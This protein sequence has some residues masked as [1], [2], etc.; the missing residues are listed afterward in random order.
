MYVSLYIIVC[1]HMC[2]GA[3]TKT[4]GQLCGASS[5]LP[6]CHGSRDP[7]LF[8][9]TGENLSRFGIILSVNV[10]IELISRKTEAGRMDFTK[11]SKFLLFTKY[12]LSV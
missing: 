9:M 2:L 6:P 1:A 3:C 8:E 5:H 12:L 11:C 4:K 10:L 7:T